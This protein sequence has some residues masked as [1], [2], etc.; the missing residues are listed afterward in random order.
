[1][2]RQLY[3]W[4]QLIL[5][6]FAYT[7]FAAVDHC[8]YPNQQEAE[9]NSPCNPDADSSACCGGGIGNICLSNGLCQGSNGAV[10]RGSCSD[11]NWDSKNCAKY[12]LGASRGGTDLI[13]CANVT[14]DDTSYC[15]NGAE[16]C[17][18]SGDGR[19]SVGPHNPTTSATWNAASTKFI[20][21]GTTS[22]TSSTSSTSIK[23]STTSTSDSATPNATSDN[24]TSGAPT[25]TDVASQSDNTSS[26][27]TAASISSDLSDGAK[28]GIGIGAVIGVLLIVGLIYALW[29]LQK[30]NK[31]L[32][33]E[34]SGNQYDQTPVYPTS[35]IAIASNS[36]NVAPPIPP[37]S[38]GQISELYGHYSPLHE[39]P[40]ES[41]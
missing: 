20:V 15:C 34:R 32:A 5:F 6:H 37:K 9:D 41:T 3:F 35:Q 24:F 4:L 11:K 26:V 36:V 14:R 30:M 13:S 40:A 27:G 33:K 21:V 38:E 18:D 10:I 22:T 2:A 25:N 16:N 29:R 28:A 23:D 19:F 39:L 8:Y 12:C 17:C 7:V 1:M 31:M